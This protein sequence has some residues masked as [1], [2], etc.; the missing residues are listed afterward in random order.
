[1]INEQAST[2]PAV[3]VGVSIGGL[4]AVT[5]L[6]IAV[7]AS[8]HPDPERRHDSREV[9]D[10]LLPLVPLLSSFG[11]TKTPADSLTGD[12]RSVRPKAGRTSPPRTHTPTRHSAT[13]TTA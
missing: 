8:V 10:R 5:T 9:L 3:W 7:A 2:H 4:Y 13:S 1:M 12:R 6:G 11:H